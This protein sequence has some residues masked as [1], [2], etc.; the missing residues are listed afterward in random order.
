MQSTPGGLESIM[1]EF[2]H[3]ASMDA[4]YLV[5]IGSRLSPATLIHF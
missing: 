5:V 2:K 1:A 4:L 3:E